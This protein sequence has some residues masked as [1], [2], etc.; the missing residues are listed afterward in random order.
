MLDKITIGTR[1]SALALWQ[2][3]H[4]ADLLRSVY[5]DM[6]IHVTPFSTRGDELLD[7][8]LPAI[9]GKG[10]FTEALEQALRDGVIDFAVHSLKDLPT[11]DADGLTVGAITARAHPGDALVSKGGLRLDDLPYGAIVGTSSRRRSA[12]LLAYRPDLRMIDI[13]GNVG[14]RIQK[15]L[16]PDSD[17]SATVLACAGLQRLEMNQH[18][19]AVL[20][21]DIMLPAPGQG[22]LAVQCRDS[23]VS[24]QLLAAINDEKTALSVMA[25]RAFLAALGGGCSLPVAAYATTDGDQLHLRGRVCAVD[26]RMVIDLRGSTTTDADS[27]F[28]LGGRLAQEAIAQGADRLIAEINT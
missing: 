6:Q 24:R 7:S 21:F 27:A 22:A 1:K 20:P 26:G 13:R 9:G 18:I 5:P 8:A 19:N 2:T 14:T 11:Q 16:A 15:A 17:Y 12:Q 23:V 10:V 3:H 28:A 25:E 4:V